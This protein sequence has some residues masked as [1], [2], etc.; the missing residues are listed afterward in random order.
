MRSYTVNTE[1]VKVSVNGNVF[2][3]IVSDAMAQAQIMDYL[4]QTAA[5]RVASPSDVEDVLRAGCNLID[6][7]LGGGACLQIFGKTP[8]SIGHII[9]LLTQICADCAA[10]YKNYLKT[11]Y[12]ED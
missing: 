1:P 5:V 7:I 6:S 10:A 3:L 12:L 2:E 8:I 4:A 9:S 11:E